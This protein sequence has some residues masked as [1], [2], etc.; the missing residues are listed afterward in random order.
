MEAV[1]ITHITP[2]PNKLGVTPFRFIA[3]GSP[4]QRRYETLSFPMQMG[5]PFLDLDLVLTF[6]LTKYPAMIRMPWT[7]LYL[8]KYCFC[9]IVEE[10][11]EQRHKSVCLTSVHV[12]WV[13]TLSVSLGS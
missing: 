6:L 7:G 4:Q 13:P 2:N 8:T 11:Q 12:S 9:S 10:Q 1:A 3:K 5:S